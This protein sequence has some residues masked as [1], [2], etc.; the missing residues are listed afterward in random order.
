MGNEFAMKNETRYKNI[1][2][3]V[4]I[5]NNIKKKTETLAVPP[6]NLT[7]GSIITSVAKGDEIMW[8]TLERNSK[9]F[10][11][12]TPFIVLQRVNNYILSWFHWRIWLAEIR[13]IKLHAWLYLTLLVLHRN[14][15][16]LI[17]WLICTDLAC[18]SYGAS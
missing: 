7:S 15:M 2:Y 13:L 16:F 14:S 3:T 6:K 11:L 8:K 18:I 10:F 1:S 12:K 9:L 17:I 5:K 4:S